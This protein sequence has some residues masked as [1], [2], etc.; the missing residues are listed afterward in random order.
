MTEILTL[1]LM[2]ALAGVLA[3]LLGIGGGALIVPVLALFF[4]NQ[5]VDPEVIMKTALGTSLATIIFTAASSVRAHH[6]R[7]A[8]RWQI[9]RRITPG[10]V[11]GSLLGAG[12]AAALPGR[13]LHAIFPVFMFLVAAQMLRPTSA[14]QA[15]RKELPGRVG[16]TG[17][18]TAIGVLSAIFG[19]GGGSLSVPFM[20]WFSVPVRNAIA[21]S[22]AIGFPI[23][24][25]STLGYVV[26]G[27]GVAG[28]PPWSI[29]Y[30][31]LPGF[32]GVVIASTLCAPF[33]AAIAHRISETALRRIFAAFLVV[34]GLRMMF[35]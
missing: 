5:G 9:V 3:G 25:A 34:L 12:V 33:G 19:I 29:G 20:T 11:L 30:V 23:A 15:H 4:Q 22:S 28:L 14:T 13:V 24:V 2:G 10:I 1:I 6:K 17:A 32:T 7:G 21:T 8:V 27:W 18:G 31:N 35:S 16:V 26:A